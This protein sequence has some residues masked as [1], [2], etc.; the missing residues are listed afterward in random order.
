MKKPLALII[1]DEPDIRELLE[2][3]LIRMDI[4]CLSAENL[5]EAYS[6][7]KKHKFDICLTDMRLPDGNG[8]K[9]VS[10]IQENNPQ[11]PV[12]VITAHGNMESAIQALKSGA[13][14]FLSKPVDLEILRTLVRAALKLRG[15][16]V[17]LVHNLVGSTEII[18]VT[19]KTISKLARSQAPVY[20]SG[21]SGTGKELVARMIHEQGARSSG[22]FV[23]VNCG[24]I[25][26]ELMESE[27]FGHVKGSF[28]GAV[29]DKEGLFRTAE[30]GTLF[31]DEVAELPLHM[32][33]KLLRTIQEK[34][35][36]SVGSTD[37]LP[38]DVRILS[39]THQDLSELVREGKFRQDL[40]YRI[41]VIEI[42]VPSLRERTED[43]P[44]LVEHILSQISS[45]TGQG[46]TNLS[47]EA[48]RKLQSYSFPGNIRELENILE[49]TLALAEGNI[50]VPD[51]LHLK[52]VPRK[53]DYEKSEHESSKINSDSLGDQLEDIERKAILD[54]LEKTR[55]NR[56]AA[57]KK[58]GLTLRALRYRLEKFGLDNK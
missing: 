41:N 35:V 24:A 38:V 36:R 55:W 45:K 2:I 44:L 53:S 9:L 47:R 22:K 5:Q 25:P 17:A 39:A 42:H 6:L 8:L 14:D 26:T 30:G 13:F 43:I 20:I 40:F 32:Q 16:D 3:T 54:V 57:A 48:L 12:A 11:L 46:T 18:N 28:T 37:E 52:E 19:R 15:S 23:P 56:T 51:D 49:R 1:D 50:I 4:D 29:S 27:L 21:E 34:T 33:V 7:L 10:F 58:L 31:F